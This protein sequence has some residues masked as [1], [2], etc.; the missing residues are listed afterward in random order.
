MRSSFSNTDDGVSHAAQLLR[1]GEPR[2]SGADDGDADSPSRA[3]PAERHDPAL[4]ERLVG[5]RLLDVADRDGLLDQAEHAR[6]LTGRRTEAPRQLGEVVRRVQ[7][8][9]RIRQRPCW[10]SAFHSGMTFWTGQ[11]VSP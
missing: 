2:R 10:T 4:R 3:T 8:E 7:R 9:R 5:D 11:P 1:G 6:R